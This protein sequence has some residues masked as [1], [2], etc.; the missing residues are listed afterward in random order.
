MLRSLAIRDMAIIRSL[1]VEFGPGLS[2]LTGETGAGKSIVI[3]A[4]G[5][6]LGGR[7]GADMVRAGASRAVIDALFDLSGAADARAMIETMGFEAPD[8][9]LTLTR[10]ISDA[11]RSSARVCGRPATAAQVRQIGETLVDIHGQHEH[12][13]LLDPRK[14][15]GFLDAWAG[16]GHV[17]LIARAAEAWERLRR[18]ETELRG[19]ETDARERL[20][21]ADLY[22]FQVHEIHGAAPEPGEDERL[23]DENRRLRNVERL[24]E[25]VAGVLASLDGPSHGSVADLVAA[26]AR[27]TEGAA[28]LDSTL[29]PLSGSLSSIRYD[30]EEATRAL[31]TY[32]DRLEADPARL[33][34]VQSRLA[35]LA[36]LKRKYGATIEEVLAFADDA[37][38]RLAAAESGEA[39]ADALKAE[40]E[41]ARTDQG[42]VFGALTAARVALARRFEEAV[43][44]GLG[45]L[46]M[47]RATFRVEVGDAPPG[48]TG[49]DAVE[50][51]LTTNPGEPLR[52]LAR[53][54]SGG[55]ISRVMLA[56]KS[57]TASRAPLPTL[58]FDEVDVGI[59]GRTASVVGE[60]LRGL[61]QAAQVLCI[62]HLPQIAVFATTQY[63]IT[64]VDE[65]GRSVVRISSL[66]EGDRI[67]ELGRM[68]AGAEV[69]DAARAH[70]RQ[71]LTRIHG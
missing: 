61:A 17:A 40:I 37:E 11:G 34:A 56:I 6:V 49:A 50:F 36:D 42:E 3:G 7:V 21:Q 64:K 62:T 67:E 71:M 66:S 4:L 9:E 23:G 70:V 57:A 16:P 5:A 22:R 48:P 28:A 51:L 33:D 14:H 24:R 63:A 41:A 27:G 10:E 44:G 2:V 25:A 46:A 30:L 26:A 18:A 38:V 31:Q 68:L 8:G 1:E 12:Q 32:L 47:E 20:R 52:P 19:I 35:V 69:T 39:R 29:E 65:A 45:E 60:K 54:A 43:T 58:V 55:E 15:L 59:G 13:S 53:I